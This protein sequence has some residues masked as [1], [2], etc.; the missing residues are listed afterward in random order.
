MLMSFVKNV[1][2]FFKRTFL[3]FGFL[4]PLLLFHW[5]F[6][7]GIKSH[8]ENIYRTNTELFL[9][10]RIFKKKIEM[11]IYNERLIFCNDLNEKRN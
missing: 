9:H 4:L 3:S 11:M 7:K 8:M 2:A 10:Y 6:H 5:F 1:L